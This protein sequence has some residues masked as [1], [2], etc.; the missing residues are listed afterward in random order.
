MML[1]DR[2]HILLKTLVERYI[3]DGHPVGS[4]A[5]SQY[6]GLDV[7][8]ATIRNVMADLENL[9]LIASPHTSAGRIP[10]AQGY[11]LFV[12]HLLTAPGLPQQMN[13]LQHTELPNDNAQH[14]IAA[15]SQL[16]S[17]LTQFAGVV[18]T[19]KRTENVLKQIEFLPLSEKRVLLILVTADGEV[20]NRIVQTE[21]HLSHAALIEAAHFLNSHCAGKTIS[22]LMSLLQ[23]DLGR[24]KSDLYD[25]MNAAAHIG[26][27]LSHDHMIIAGEHQLLGLNDFGTDM[28][29]MRQLFELFEQKSTLLKLMQLGQNAEG[30]QI[31]IGNESGI[32]TLDECS[33]IAAPYRVN[34]EIVG[35][36]GVI[37][38]TRM[39][40]DRVIPIVNITAQLLSSALTQSN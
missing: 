31:Y 23:G 26:S 30:I 29:R 13:E 38:P 24:V 22:N 11:R 28:A 21:H 33:V 8:A 25:L 17:Q 6:A 9:G 27:D 19:P 20:Q 16:L 18:I 12:D 2:S 3:A 5:L 14:S 35:T 34:N 1:N 32:A 15:A 10:T 37:G 4:K 39:A 36:L 7:S 40:Y